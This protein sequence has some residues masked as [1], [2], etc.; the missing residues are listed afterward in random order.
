MTQVNNDSS[1][2]DLAFTNM[3][4]WD[5]GSAG[6]NDATG[7]TSLGLGDSAV[8]DVGVAVGQVA[9]G[10][11]HHDSDYLQMSP[12]NADA[13]QT[14]S[15][16]LKINQES[17]DS[18]IVGNVEDSTGDVMLKIIPHASTSAGTNLSKPYINFD[19]VNRLDDSDPDTQAG[20]GLKWTYDGTSGKT[21]RLTA[22]LHPTLGTYFSFMGDSGTLMTVGDN[23]VVCSKILGVSNGLS[24]NSNI[25]GTHVINSINTMGSSSDVKICTE[26]AIQEY[27]SHRLG[28]NQEADNLPDISTQDSDIVTG[29]L[30]LMTSGAIYDYIAA[31]PDPP[32]TTIKSATGSG[33]LVN[34][35]EN[36]SAGGPDVEISIDPTAG[37]TADNWISTTA[38]A[39]PTA[40]PNYQ[41]SVGAASDSQYQIFKMNG[42][43][44]SITIDWDNADLAGEWRLLVIYG[45]DTGDIDIIPPG[46][47]VD[48]VSLFGS[49]VLTPNHDGRSWDNNRACDMVTIQKFNDNTGV[50]SVVSPLNNLGAY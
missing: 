23:S 1:N 47:G 35:V 48:L 11:H 19:L 38:G 34:G 24:I 21:M 20:G 45:A 36:T 33:L 32:Q 2:W 17:V 26:L 8:R 31:L 7:R 50:I 44:G 29:G 43:G 10:N 14:I 28:F 16:P 25:T 9:A 4:K 42:S 5:G 41:W 49:N 3:N 12:S 37:L 22:N 27:I 13:Q 40:A 15:S 18:H 30:K 46:G 6:L 39:I